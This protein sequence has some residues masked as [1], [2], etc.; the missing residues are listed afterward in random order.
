LKRAH[1]AKK[2]ATAG[3]TFEKLAERWVADEARRKKWTEDYEEEVKASIRNHLATLDGLPIASITAAICSPITRACEKKAPDMARKVHQRLRNIM[4]YAVEHGAIAANPIPVRRSG[5]KTEPKHLPATLS[6]SGVGEILRQADKAEC[7]KGVRRAHLLCTFTAQRISEVVGAR[8]SEFDLQVGTWAIPRD[9]MKRKDEARGPHLVPIPS[10]LLAKLQEWKREDGAD[11]A[12]VCPAPSGAK[13]ISRESVEKHYRRTLQLANKHSP[14]GWR[15]V[16]S[17]WAYEAAKQGD[18]IEAQL[19][20]V[21][22]NSVQQAYD[23]ASRLE[24]RRHL[25][26][27][28]ED[29]L[30]AARDGAQVIEL[31]E[32]AA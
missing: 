18:V 14:H 5:A 9:R 10:G 11:G 29:E 1:R 12:F 28:F 27:W 7:C 20:H 19:D 17:T 4:D 24:L 22:G 15:S 26:Q 2:A 23:R 16:F 3:N 32:R 21:V 30:V 8:W 31:A 6:R 25:V 13:H